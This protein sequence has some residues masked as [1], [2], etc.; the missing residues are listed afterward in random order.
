M[1]SKN[2]F[3]RLANRRQKC[4][5]LAVRDP[6]NA[7]YYLDL[8]AQLESKLKAG[9][10]CVRCGRPLHTATSI[11]LGFGPECQEKEQHD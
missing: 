4:L 5:M 10:V 11:A 3:G 7:A 8:A 2:A 9:V 1:T 6:M